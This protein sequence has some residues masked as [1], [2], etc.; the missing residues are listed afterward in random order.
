MRCIVACLAIGTLLACGGDGDVPADSRDEAGESAAEAEVDDWPCEREGYPCTWEEVSAETT[1]Q[2]FALADEALDRFEPGA[3]SEVV[4]WLEAQ[5][6]VAEAGEEDPSLV[7]FRVEG[8]RPIMVQ[9]PLPPGPIEARLQG[10]SDETSYLDSDV[11]LAGVGSALIASWDL[12]SSWGAEL[13]SESLLLPGVTGRDRNEDRRVNQRDQR[14]A[15]ILESTY[16]EDCYEA[17]APEDEEEEARQRA[18][19]EARCEREEYESVGERIEAILEENP[20][21][22]GNVQRL[23]NQE[24]DFEAIASWADYDVIHIDG[25]GS[26]NKMFLG[27]EIAW[28][29]H[30]KLRGRAA[31]RRGVDPTVFRAGK[32]GPKKR[33]WGVNHRFFRKLY[34]DGLDRTFIFMNGCSTLGH[35]DRST[36]PMAD[37]LLGEQSMY[38]GWGGV[39]NR[40]YEVPPE[41][42]S[43]LVMGWSGEEA[44]R[45]LPLFLDQNLR[46]A[47]GDPVYA[48]KPDLLDCDDTEVSLEDLAIMEGTTPEELAEQGGVEGWCRR[49]NEETREKHPEQQRRAGHVLGT[50]GSDMRIREVAKLLHPPSEL[51]G[52]GEGGSRE[53]PVVKDGDDLERLIVGALGDGEDDWLRVSVEVEAIEI[54]ELGSTE[55]RIE[56]DGEPIGEPRS[57]EGARLIDLGAQGDGHQAY[58]LDLDGERT[59]E[60]GKD[61]EAGTEYELE[62]IV[63][64][65]EGG[66]SRYS[67]RL[68]GVECRSGIGSDTGDLEGSLGGGTVLVFEPDDRWS[69]NRQRSAWLYTEGP[70][71]PNLHLEARQLDE[72]SFRLMVDLPRF[73][74]PGD[75]FVVESRSPADTKIGGNLNIQGAGTDG[76]RDLHYSFMTGTARISIQKVTRI[77]YYRSLLGWV[78]GE[79]DADLVGWASPPP[80][81]SEML[82][83]PH[84]F[85]GRFRAE[86]TE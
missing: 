81:G 4:G 69:P 70:R 42:Y 83:V 55:L 5:P 2:T 71:P 25:H 10:R 36:P 50:R 7:W 66:E 23:R 29:G 11:R 77:D 40:W 85:K 39:T 19:I 16:W 60:L 8:G 79:I 35:P 59:L 47:Y 13:R 26:R 49:Q 58:R 68:K 63:D 20:A 75:R 78:C 31:Q 62:A 80:G 61:L 3:A 6:N 1:E 57:L 18:S 46:D 15:L 37:Q 34:P 21:Y 67:A 73:P 82:K 72:H 9:G 51:L 24:V 38:V 52:S 43:L 65:P 22:K 84:R 64:L 30:G 41:L 56:L 44:L 28:P 32:Q 33:V 54:D 14:K 53:Q 17:Y 45:S 48:E 74:K 12:A 76:S 27:T 86:I